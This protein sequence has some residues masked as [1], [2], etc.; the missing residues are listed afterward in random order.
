MFAPLPDWLE[1][2]RAHLGAEV[3]E[4]HI[5]W[6]LLADGCAWKLKK[7]LTLPFLD[8][9]T[10]EKRHFFCQEE[11]R[12]NRRFAPELYLGLDEAGNSGEWA[13]KMRRFPESQ[14]LDRVCARAS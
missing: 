8:Y 7:P 11:L 1:E 9:G 6:L 10:Q 3:I 2:F 12:L 4:T 5:S 14:R 13:V